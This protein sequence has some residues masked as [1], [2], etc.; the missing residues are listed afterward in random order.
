MSDL[1]DRIH[2]DRFIEP[3][4][5]WLECIDPFSP[6]EC[7]LAWARES[8]AWTCAY[9]YHD[10]L[11]NETD[12][13]LNGYAQGAFPVVELQISKAALRLATWLD[14]LA[15]ESSAAGNSEMEA[16]VE[17]NTQQWLVGTSGEL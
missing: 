1:V 15:V 8:N 2:Q 17:E 5:N 7:A 3:T 16:S 9:V 4:A 13:L 11:N 14:L 6:V 10:R 12:L